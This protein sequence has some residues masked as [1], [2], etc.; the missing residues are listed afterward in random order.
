M[1]DTLLYLNVV[2]RKSIRERRSISLYCIYRSCLEVII[3]NS[4]QSIPGQDI[5]GFLSYI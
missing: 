4:R 2:C 5:F 1:S 3:T